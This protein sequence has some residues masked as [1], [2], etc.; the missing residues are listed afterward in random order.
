MARRTLTEALDAILSDLDEALR[1]QP[2]CPHAQAR[3]CLKLHSLCG[4]PPAP[5]GDPGDPLPELG[6]LRELGELGRLWLATLPWLAVVASTSL[7]RTHQGQPWQA[8]DQR[9]Y[10]GLRDRLRVWRVL[11]AR[12]PRVDPHP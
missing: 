1:Q 10:L 8:G 5:G 11:I 7:W 6:E 9:G 4:A 12:W 3:A 2:P